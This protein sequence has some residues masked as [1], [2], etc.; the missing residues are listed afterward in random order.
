MIMIKVNQKG[1]T[2]I[3][4]ESMNTVKVKQADSNKLLK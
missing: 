1:K 4:V 3:Y 2:N